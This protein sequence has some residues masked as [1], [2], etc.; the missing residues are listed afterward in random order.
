MSNRRPRKRE[1]KFVVR[2]PQGMRDHIA[3]KANENVRSMNSEFIHRLQ[4]TA[5]L[6]AE[7]ERALRTIDQ[8]LAVNAAERSGD[9]T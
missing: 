1:D 3:A 7:L 8:L 2:L 4:A 9:C 5:R 6:E